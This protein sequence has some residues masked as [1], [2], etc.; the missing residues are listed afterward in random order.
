MPTGL[1]T[2]GVRCANQAARW[3]FIP[4]Q[5]LF[6]HAAD[7]KDLEPL[8]VR[9]VYPVAGREVRHCGVCGRLAGPKY[10]FDMLGTRSAA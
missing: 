9:A 2:C 3:G 10:R 4:E 8:S 1:G 7:V 6:D 5:D